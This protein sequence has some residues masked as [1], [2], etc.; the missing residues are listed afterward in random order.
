MVRL[1]PLC[2][3]AFLFFLSAALADTLS[4]QPPA[5]TQSSPLAAMNGLFPEARRA[6]PLSLPEVLALKPM[7][8]FK[9]CE[10]C[11]EMVVIPAGSFVMGAPAGEEGSTSAERPQHIV[12]FSSPF[13]VG[14]FAVTFDEWEACVSAHGCSHRPSDHGWGRGKQPVI[15]LLWQDAKEYVAWLS[16]TTG[17]T[18]RL[19]SEAEREYVTRAGTQSAFWWGDFF[20]PD[21]ANCDCRLIGSLD[22]KPDAFP[23]SSL[24]TRPVPVHAFAPNQWGLY[25]VHGNVYDW[26]EDCWNESY[27]GAPTDGSSWTEMENMSFA[28]VRLAEVRGPSDPPHG[29][30]SARPIVWPI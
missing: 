26:V 28:V 25:Q 29:S 4:P 21:K 11:P 30:G 14:R 15:D 6:K 12:H 16:R 22:P 13:A 7:D 24:P 27:D 5:A 19:L 20:G 10:Q 8:H 17:K 9:E 1:L 18:Y 23:S 3:I 2:A